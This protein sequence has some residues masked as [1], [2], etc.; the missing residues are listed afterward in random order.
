MRF[1]PGNKQAEISKVLI[2]ILLAIFG[3]GALLVPPG[4]GQSSKLECFSERWPHEKSDLA[5]DPAVHFGRLDNG[6]RYTIME[7][8]TPRDRVAIYLY[9]DVGS[10]HETE[11]EKGYAHFLEHMLFNGSTHFPPGELVRYFQ[12]I[13]M[14]FG[15]DTNAFTSYDQTVYTIVLPKGNMEDL[16]KGF[17][18]ISDYARGALLL[19]SEVE[20]E[21]G[22]I[23]AEKLARDSVNYRMHVASRE[24]ALQGTLLAEREPIGEV[25][26]I[27]AA[28]SD[29]L[30]NFYDKWYR[31]ENM[32]LV[33]VG[34]IERNEVEQLVKKSFTSL[35]G[36]GEPPGCPTLGQL[37]KRGL[38]S[39]YYHEPDAG[40]VRISLE[41][42]WDKEKDNDSFQLQLKTLREY[43]ATLIVQKR[44]VK[45]T[46][47]K[48]EL[49]SNPQ[50]YSGD[51]LDRVGYS[52]LSASTTQERWRESLQTLDQSLRQAIAYGITESELA[53]AKKELSSYFDSQAQKVQGRESTV[54][55]R[56]II[57]SLNNERV[58]QSPQQERDL[59]VAALQ[60]FSV[61]DINEAFIGLMD[62]NEK[63]IETMGNIVIES[64]N[65]K[66][67]ILAAYKKS[68]N[69]PVSQYSEKAN[70]TFPY[71]VVE[72]DPVAPFQH[73]NHAAIDVDSYR[74][75]NGVILNLKKT[76]FKKN[77]V[78]ILVEFGPGRQTEPLPGLAMVAQT[79]IEESGSGKMTASAIKDAL[80][81]S[82]VEYQF[83]IDK[84]RFAFSAKALKEETELLVKTLH[85][86]FSDPGLRETSF[87]NAMVYYKQL[88]ESMANDIRGAESLYIERFFGGGNTLF[89][90]ASWEEVSKIELSQIEKWV[91]PI[92]TQSAPQISVVGDFNKEEILSLINTYFGTLPE[93]K[94]YFP[95]KEEIDFPQ[96]EK[97][98]I[99]VKSQL[100]KS[101]IV[102]GWETEGF[103]DIHV[104]RRLGMLASILEERIRLSIREK[105]GVSYSPSVYNA[106][107][108][109][110]PEYGVLYARLIVDVANIDEVKEAVIEISKN[111]QLDDIEKEELERARKPLLTL[112][113]DRV[114][115]NGYWL[116]TVL[117]QSAIYP[118]QLVWPTTIIEDNASI[119]AAEMTAYAG[120][121]LQPAAAAVAVAEPESESAE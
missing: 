51:L 7:N 82:S 69:M 104:V 24:N 66:D 36:V 65:P 85:T 45:I 37:E 4:Y 22:I 23:L 54:L 74:Y 58:F 102:F 98:E 48:T 78:E 68:R 26:T 14:S 52:G 2:T 47:M 87:L 40:N 103:N 93:R 49:F 33:V 34:D 118:D 55:A 15:A 63:L 11:K 18:V 71:G 115:T 39:F 110:I 21:R 105:L 113:K 53:I 121:Y 90:M 120:K 32:T 95:A 114:R 8:D 72:K 96:G 17:L 29:S 60:S 116:N 107:S 62:R 101:L 3:V 56:Q 119:T 25:E 106:S 13:G 20:S 84:T 38:H 31:P 88:Y 64:D 91:M 42:Y 76:D 97:L 94:R 89:G 50:V 67:V 112:L 108:R 1:F 41:S 81:G 35:K 61:K 77:E 79:V 10:I 12:S 83:G 99:K 44:L 92:F 46:E 43:I 19:E 16:E 27:K 117:S 5:P 80:A 111:L 9:V 30:R 73:E 59:Y 109:F 70:Q 28:T 100:D 57:R 6:F 75:E 86:L